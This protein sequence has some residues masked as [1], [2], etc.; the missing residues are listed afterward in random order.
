MRKI[1]AKGSK[2][3]LSRPSTLPLLPVTSFVS[4]EAPREETTVSFTDPKSIL[5][6]EVLG[7]ASVFNDRLGGSRRDSSD[8]ES[9]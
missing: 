4:R 8:L 7:H 6:R 5:Q 1:K 9:R 2:V 3:T